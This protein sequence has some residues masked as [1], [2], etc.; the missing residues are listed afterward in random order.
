MAVSCFN[1]VVL[2]VSQNNMS[3]MHPRAAQALSIRTVIWGLLFW[4]WSSTLN[5]KWNTCSE[6]LFTFGTVKRSY[7]W[8]WLKLL[9]SLSDV[10]INFLKLKIKGDLMSNA[11]CRIIE[12]TVFILYSQARPLREPFWV[13]CS[14]T[15][16]VYW[17]A[18]VCFVGRHLIIS[19]VFWETLNPQP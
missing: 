5:L 17:R 16:C 9:H 13:K 7:I 15:R 1:G 8:N 14:E 10:N 12:L 3:R 18:S 2:W 4:L 11:V 19:A 6:V